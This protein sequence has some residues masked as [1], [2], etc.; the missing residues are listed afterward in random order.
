MNGAGDSPD[1]VFRDQWQQSPFAD[2]Y[3]GRFAAALVESLQL[4]THAGPDVLGVGFSSPDIVGHAFGPRS[5]EVQD[6]YARLDETIGILLDRLDALV[7]RNNYIVALTSDHGV[8]IIPE[9]RTPL[10]ARTADE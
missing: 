8:A 6:M 4:G 3:L 2:A 1:N 5:R 7:G 10:G 9:Q